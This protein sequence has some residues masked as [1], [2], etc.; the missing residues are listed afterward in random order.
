MLGRNAEQKQATKRK[1]TKHVFENP[2][3]K[4]QHCGVQWEP[5]QEARIWGDW[6]QKYERGV[7]LRNV[8]FVQKGE[9]AASSFKRKTKTA[10]NFSKLTLERA[11]RRRD[12][13]GCQKVWKTP[14]SM[15]TVT[16]QCWADSWKELERLRKLTRTDKATTAR[17]RREAACDLPGSTL[18]GSIYGPLGG[19]TISGIH[20]DRPRV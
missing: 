16:G 8:R 4:R 9:G 12:R 19:R 7:L 18:C 2:E 15:K 13:E 10:V 20:S 1:R 5:E 3:P 11:Q 17:T 6:V 14:A